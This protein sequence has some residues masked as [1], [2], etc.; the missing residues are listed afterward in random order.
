MSVAITH[1]F[2]DVDQIGTVI[3]RSTAPDPYEGLKGHDYIKARNL[4]SPVQRVQTFAQIAMPLVE[5]QK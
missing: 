4:N 3:V 1:S 5:V 2:S